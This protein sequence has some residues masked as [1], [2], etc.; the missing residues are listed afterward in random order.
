MGEEEWR[1]V[2]RGGREEGCSTNLMWSVPKSS[3]KK[4]RNKSENS[5]R[6]TQPAGRK[7]AASRQPVFRKCTWRA[8]VGGFSDDRQEMNG[9]MR[10]MRETLRIL[11]TARCT[12]AEGHQ[13]WN[14]LIRTLQNRTFTLI[15]LIS[16]RL[17]V[18]HQKCRRQQPSNSV[19]TV[20]QYR[21]K[22]TIYCFLICKNSFSDH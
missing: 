21:C 8:D 18:L 17:F 1:E 4:V 13:G 15:R 10:E 11:V 3:R 6:D 9:V 16:C 22:L 20:S 5:D 2:K 12:R 19:S 14:V 7:Q